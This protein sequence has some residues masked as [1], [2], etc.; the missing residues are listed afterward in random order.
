MFAAGILHYPRGNVILFKRGCVSVA[1]A[2][3][4]KMQNYAILP[5]WAK[6]N[7]KKPF[8]NLKNGKFAVNLHL[9][10]ENVLVCVTVL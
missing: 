4:Y 9:H 10:V 3:L 1:A 5:S 7:L 8:A 2:L 6:R